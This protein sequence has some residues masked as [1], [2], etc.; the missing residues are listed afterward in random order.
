MAAELILRARKDTVRHFLDV[1]ATRA[2]SAVQYQPQKHL[3]RRAL[4]YLLGKEVVRLG[5]DGRYWLDETAAA[6]WR[7]ETGTRT[8]L[9]VGGL[10]AGLAA[11]AFA[12]YRSSRKPEDQN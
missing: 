4:A 8:A 1:G 5:A 12:R 6:V 11:F 3:Q 2:D 9:I 7:R 10:A